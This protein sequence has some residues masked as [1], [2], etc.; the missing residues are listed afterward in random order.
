M[1]V[2]H[3]TLFEISCHGSL[4]HLSA[5]APVFNPVT[6]NIVV[7]LNTTA[8]T[9]LTTL[10]ATDADNDALTYATASTGGAV[11]FAV[12]TSTGNANL[13]LANLLDVEYGGIQ[14]NFKVFVSDSVNIGKNMGNGMCGS[15][16]G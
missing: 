7:G 8:G 13:V 11:Y 12:D 3:T 1:L 15:R 4:L 9:V 2:V 16:G 10:T 5:A 6:Y 14:W